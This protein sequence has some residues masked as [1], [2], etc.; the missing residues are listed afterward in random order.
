M[1]VTPSSQAEAR[2]WLRLAALL[3]AEVRDERRADLRRVPEGN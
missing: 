2:A 3:L 1:E